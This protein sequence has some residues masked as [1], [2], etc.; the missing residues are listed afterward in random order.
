MNNMLSYSDTVKD[1]S[2]VNSIGRWVEALRGE[3]EKSIILLM[4]LLFAFPR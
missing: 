3:H 1:Q 4:L 2:K